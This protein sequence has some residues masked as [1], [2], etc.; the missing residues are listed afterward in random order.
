MHRPPPI[1]LG[2]WSWGANPFRYGQARG[3]P[4]RGREVSSVRGRCRISPKVKEIA[5]PSIFWLKARRFGSSEQQ[6]LRPESGLLSFPLRPD[7][8][9]RRNVS[10]P[11]QGSS[12]RGTLV[13]FLFL[14]RNSLF[15]RRKS[16]D[17]FEASPF[18]PLKYNVIP[19]P[20]AKKVRIFP[21][22]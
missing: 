3:P 19:V 21:V 15:A 1:R 12:S 5:P 22:L 13:S 8:Q 6:R 16:P 2:V 20:H 7:T 14:A 11:L 18:K 17:L 4:S 10:R 9:A